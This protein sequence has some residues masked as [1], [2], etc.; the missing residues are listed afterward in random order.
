MI[1]LGTITIF[2]DDN[3]YQDRHV[4]STAIIYKYANDFW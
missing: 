1:I 4:I 3:K 2:R